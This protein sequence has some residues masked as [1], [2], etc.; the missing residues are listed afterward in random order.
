MVDMQGALYAGMPGLNRV[1]AELAQKT[2]RQNL[3]G[4]LKE[5]VRQAD[6]LMGV[7]ALGVF[8]EEIIRGMNKDAIV[9][10]MANPVPEIDYVA[11]KAGR[12]TRCR[13]RAFG[14]T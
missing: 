14:C 12:S 3:R 4:S 6:V 5:A 11:A 7:S 9:F 13:D 2:N 10:A 8:T 1:Q